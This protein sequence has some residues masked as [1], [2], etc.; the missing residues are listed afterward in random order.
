[1]YIARQYF[2]YIIEFNID[3]IFILASEISQKILTSGGLPQIVEIVT[4]P[5]NVVQNEALIA[6]TVLATTIKRK[7]WHTRESKPCEFQSDKL[8][9]CVV[10]LNLYSR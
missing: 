6:I 10:V 2:K 7:Y 5:R 9:M 3:N 1:M 4:S 8:Q